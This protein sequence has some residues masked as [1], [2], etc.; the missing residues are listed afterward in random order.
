M[1][2]KFGIT[3]KLD[4]SVI[5]SIV[6]FLLLIFTLRYFQINV[7]IERQYSYVHKIEGILNGEIGKEIITREGKSYLSDYPIFSDW[8]C[9]LYTLIFPLLLILTATAKII[10]ELLNISMYGWSLNSGLNFGV[11]ILLLISIVLYLF[12]HYKNNK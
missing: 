5:G 6:W 11:F 7:F 2:F 1:N 8:M 9:L 10:G 4:F 12:V 3:L